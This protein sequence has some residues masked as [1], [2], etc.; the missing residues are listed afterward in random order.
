MESL[1]P[2]TVQILSI[3]DY[4]REDGF[5]VIN[6]NEIVS[7]DCNARKEQ[8]LRFLHDKGFGN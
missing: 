8:I 4:G 6:I 3:D 1:T 7:A 5:V 2:Q